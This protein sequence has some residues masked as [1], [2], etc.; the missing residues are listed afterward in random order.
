RILIDVL[1]IAKHGLYEIATS[2]VVNQVR[3][4]VRPEWVISH[5]L[6]DRAAVRKRTCFLEILHRRAGE[7]LPEQLDERF[8]PNGIDNAL[9]GQNGIRI[10]P[11]S[12]E[13]H[14]DKKDNDPKAM[15]ALLCVAMGLPKR[16]RSPTKKRAGPKD[17]P[18][19]KDKSAASD[20]Q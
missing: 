14:T 3:K 10:Q 4:E 5:V 13:K 2:Y 11:R 19:C 18:L 1:R 9:V 20:L 6:N 17:R 16:K 12:T 8:I 15:H 7:S